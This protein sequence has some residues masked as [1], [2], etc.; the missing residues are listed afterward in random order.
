M[1]AKF[2]SYNQPASFLWFN[3]MY[4]YTGPVM[5]K[6][7]SI[8]HTATNH[9]RVCYVYNSHV[10]VCVCVCACAC[11]CACVCVCMLC[12]YICMYVHKYI[13]M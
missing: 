10:C 12:M 3:H 4:M 7:C 11:A 9:V 5:G 6:C 8:L 13:R 1:V 2:N